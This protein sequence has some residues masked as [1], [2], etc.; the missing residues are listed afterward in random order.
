MELIANMLNA[1]P[2]LRCE[3]AVAAWAE[4]EARHIAAFDFNPA[5]M[6]SVASISP[7]DDIN[8]SLGLDPVLLNR[9][10]LGLLAADWACYPDPANRETYPHLH[11]AVAVFPKGFRL[12]TASAGDRVLPIGY[13]AFHPISPATFAILRDAPQTITS[14]CQITPQPQEPS[15]EQY[16]Y[17]YN[18]GI[19]PRFHRTE[20]SKALMRAFREDVAATAHR[21]LAAIVV[22][23]DGKRVIE[24]FGLRPSG[25]ITHD[26]HEEQ[27]YVSDL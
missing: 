26:G 22:S 24:R 3:E 9:F 12:W 6:E 11:H 5:R 27:A 19:L 4:L 25:V 14:R 21:G 8:A 2:D 16:C 23:P 17:L 7:G 1:V 15:G 13:S 20:A 10:V 18:I